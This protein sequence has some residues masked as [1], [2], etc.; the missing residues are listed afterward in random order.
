MSKL[1]TVAWMLVAGPFCHN[2]QACSKLAASQSVEVRSG[3]IDAL[4]VLAVIHGA[5]DGS[6]ML[7]KFIVG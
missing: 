6:T 1:A 5:G 3:R 4:A 2:L 7:R